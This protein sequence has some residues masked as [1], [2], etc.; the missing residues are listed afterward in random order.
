M[1]NK[2]AKS[3]LWGQNPT[4]M[5]KNISIDRFSGGLDGGHIKGSILMIKRPMLC[6]YGCN[7]ARIISI[8]YTSSKT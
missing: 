1:T 3:I 7:M 4:S 2:Y 6:S 5:Q 8:H